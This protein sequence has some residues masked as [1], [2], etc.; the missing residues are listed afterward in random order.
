M[1]GL[2]MIECVLCIISTV[3]MIIIDAFN[4]SYKK[5]SKRKIIFTLGNV[6][7]SLVSIFLILKY[8][9]LINMYP[10]YSIVFLLLTLSTLGCYVI[11]LFI[12]LLDRSL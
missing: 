10:I 9:N 5:A 4:K 2:F 12:K 8:C 11:A 3:I 1:T 7:S 6:G